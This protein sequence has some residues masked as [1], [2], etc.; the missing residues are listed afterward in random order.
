MEHEIRQLRTL[1]ETLE[2]LYSSVM[3]KDVDYGSG[4]LGS[5]ST[6]LKPGA[7]KIFALS[8]AIT[9]DAARRRPREGR[10]P[11]R[12]STRP[13]PQVGFRGTAGGHR[14]PVAAPPRGP[15]MTHWFKIPRAS[16]S[17]KAPAFTMGEAWVHVAEVIDRWILI[18]CGPRTARC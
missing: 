12:S 16:G 10:P 3:S 1:M 4:R 14:W 8:T 11:S 7:E 5:K 2:K 18:R 13:R 17:I 9:Y 15:G 6:L